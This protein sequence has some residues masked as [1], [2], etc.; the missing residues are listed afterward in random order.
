[1]KVSDIIARRSSPEN[2]SGPKAP[3]QLI[4]ESDRLAK[5]RLDIERE[6]SM[7]THQQTL[8]DE[9]FIMPQQPQQMYNQQPQPQPQQRM[10]MQEQVPT[11]NNFRMTIYL[12]TGQKLPVVFAAYPEEVVLMLKNIDAEIEAGRV[13]TI[14]DFKIPGN[15]IAYIDLQGR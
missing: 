3:D 10:Q 2:E 13:L 11:K 12:E 9:E 14:G 1:M 8:P 4:S 5:Q 7:S 15:R 6:L